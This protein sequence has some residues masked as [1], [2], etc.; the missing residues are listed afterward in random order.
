MDDAIPSVDAESG[1]ALGGLGGLVDSAVLDSGCA[2]DEE[3]DGEP[4]P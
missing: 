1:T 3:G 4:L 2:G